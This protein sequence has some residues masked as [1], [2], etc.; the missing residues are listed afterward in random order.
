M[1]VTSP[2]QF[3]HLYSINRYSNLQLTCYV[4]RSKV[5]L[6]PNS[7]S[8]LPNVLAQSHPTICLNLPSWF[9][10]LNWINP[11]VCFTIVC[12]WVHTCYLF[13]IASPKW[14]P[15][16]LLT[17]FVYQKAGEL[18]GSDLGNGITDCNQGG[19]LSLKWEEEIW[20]H[21]RKGSQFIREAEFCIWNSKCHC[22]LI[23]GELKTNQKK[24][25]S[26]L[27]S[28]GTRLKDVA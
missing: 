20:E 26:S 27:G 6:H 18:W 28:F 19:A 25:Q 9:Q 21:L 16:S 13:G 3:W 12:Q 1:C 5:V 17:L 24:I 14:C 22:T 10:I 11:R 2:C 7:L 23:T 4:D 15:K 8:F